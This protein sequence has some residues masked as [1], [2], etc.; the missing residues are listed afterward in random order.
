M[1]R[2]EWRNSPL[3]ECVISVSAGVSVNSEDRPYGPDE[4]G[5]LKT[6]AVSAGLFKEDENKTVISRDRRRV[7]EPVR[8]GSVLLSRMNTPQLV[9]ESCF[10]ET[11]NPLL[12]LPDR[13]WQIRVESSR[14]DARWLSYILQSPHVSAAI[15]ALATGTSG[16]MKN[17]SKRS[18][19]ALKITLPPL[20]D[21]EQIVEILDTLDHQIRT[22]KRLLMKLKSI[23]RGLLLSSFPKEPKESTYLGDLVS[24]ARPIVY[25]ILMPGEHFPNG[26]PV[27]KVKD[28]KSGR[29]DRADLLLTNPA[30]DREYRRSRLREGDVL[31]SI[32]GTVGRVC[33]VPADLTGANITQ[34][35]ARISVPMRINRYV[36]HY[37]ESPAA[38]RFI[39][40]EIVGLAVRGINLRDVRRIVIPILPEDEALSIANRLEASQAV[41]DDETLQLLK[42]SSLKL[43]MMTDLL[44]GRVRVSRELAS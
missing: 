25:G 36:A 12:F 34:D 29:V 30:I 20:V 14:V 33:V 9:G 21:Q 42:L 31:L 39:D 37:L 2:S 26:V 16:S 22:T 40:S 44:T 24:S 43:G 6:S 38:Q 10:V 17:I 13:L 35:T 23:H 41:I 28:M 11:D 32:R 15:K 19:L 3:A 27:V 8:G 4:I 7:A 1:R 5:V 18:L